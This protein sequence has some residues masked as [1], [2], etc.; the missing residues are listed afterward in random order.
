MWPKLFIALFSFLFLHCDNGFGI[1]DV[2]SYMRYIW[3]KLK[4]KIFERELQKGA[5][6]AKLEKK[7]LKA[8]N[9]LKNN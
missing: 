2:M 5:I 9:K 7:V 4:K 3:T 6:K 1:I 8:K